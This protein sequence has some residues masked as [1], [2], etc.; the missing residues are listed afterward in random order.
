VTF[1]EARC[2]RPGGQPRSL[3]WTQ[4]LILLA[5][6]GSSSSVST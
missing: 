1:A 4:F 5:S 3:S 2:D 6:F